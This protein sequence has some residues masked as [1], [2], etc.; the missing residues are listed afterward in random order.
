M[1]DNIVDIEID[2][3]QIALLSMVERTQAVIHFTV[4]GIILHANTNFLNALEYSADA[5]VGQHHRMFVDPKYA[6]SNEYAQFWQNLKSGQTFTDQF[7]RRTRTG[8]VIWIQATY[9]PVFDTEGTVSRIVKVAT[10]ITARQEAIHAVANGLIQLRKGDLTHR[11]PVSELPDMAVVGEAFNRTMDDWNTLLGRVSTITNV[12]QSIEETLSLSSQELSHRSSTQASTLSKTARALNQLDNTVR[13]AATKAQSADTVAKDTRGK[14]ERNAK[15]VDDIKE[16]M[17]LIQTSST[18]ISKIVNTIEAISIQ[19][20]LLALNAAIEAARAGNAGRGFAV[21]AKEVQRLA[22]RSSEA[23]GE[24][25]DLIGESGHHVSNGV[26][27]VNRAG[28]DLNS[29]FDGFESLSSTVERIAE[30]ITSQ[31]AALS[32]INQAT[33]QMEHMTQE[34][35][36]MAA[37]TTSACGR[38]ADAC[39]ALASQVSRFQTT[40]QQ[41]Y[42]T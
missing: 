13:N 21:V 4:D 6:Q 11:I 39:N 31:S 14:A 5:V 23:A 15:L 29:F 42:T 22:Q 26:L 7:P 3:G 24:I 41:C 27:L 28:V 35:A 25:S 40:V 2:E 17:V 33:G 10:D 1:L 19:T 30:G 12:V 38:L 32:E 37:E 36:Q 20:N 16:A 18:R 9:A 34:N 8:R